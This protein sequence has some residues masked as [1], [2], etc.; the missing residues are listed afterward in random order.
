MSFPRADEHQRAVVRIGN[1]FHGFSEF[2]TIKTE[3]R[4]RRETGDLMICCGVL[5]FRAPLTPVGPMR[6]EDFDADVFLRWLC[7]RKEGSSSE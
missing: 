7:R 6:N 4:L 2:A 3:L 1:H 5:E